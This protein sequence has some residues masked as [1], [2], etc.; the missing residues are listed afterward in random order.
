MQNKQVFF[1]AIAQNS[2]VVGRNGIFLL[3]FSSPGITYYSC[4][5]MYSL[6]GNV[7][8]YLYDVGTIVDTIL[9]TIVGIDQENNIILYNS[10]IFLRG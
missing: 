8:I 4:M 9:R 1:H 5:V 7:A 10:G 2:Q 3:T 6:C